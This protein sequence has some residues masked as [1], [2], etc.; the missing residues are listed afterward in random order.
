MKKRILISTVFL[1]IGIITY[2]FYGIGVLSK[3]NLCFS[4]IRNYI[5]DICWTISFFF[6]SINFAF[7]IF[8]KYI[9]INAIY[10]LTVAFIFEVLQ[11]FGIVGGTFDIID[12]L[13]YIIFVLI[14]CIIEKRE[15][16]N[17][18]ENEKSI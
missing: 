11:L 4:L 7:I 5:P 14:S 2:Y 1:I 8:K 12:I 3:N 9:L 17:E 18:N 13:I 15:R 16:K 10:V 6:M